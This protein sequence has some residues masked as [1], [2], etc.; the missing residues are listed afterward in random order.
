M[1]TGNTK[2]LLLDNLAIQIDVT[3][4]N[5]WNLNTGLTITSV[6]KWNNAVSDDIDLLDFG[7]TA[8]DN[9]RTESMLY[10]IILNKNETYLNLYRVGAYSEISN[11]ISYENLN[12]NSVTGDSV[13]NYFN[14]NGGYFQG[15]FKLFNY[16]YEIL[17]A[18][19][20]DGYTIETMAEILS[21]TSGIF[22]SMGLRAED[23]YNPFFSGETALISG[24]SYIYGNDQTE[25]INTYSGI[26]T[27]EGNYLN[28]NIP[29]SVLLDKFQKP[30]NSKVSVDNISAQLNNI[31]NNII[32]FEITTDKRLKY[33]F[34]DNVGNL[35]QEESPKQI[36][37]IGWTLIDIVFKPYD[38]INDYNYSDYKCY[39]R[40]KGD[41]IFYI[42][43]RIFW[44]VNN[45]DEYYFTEIQN[46]K[47]KQIG[48]P[49]NISWGGGS[50][51]LKNSYH[52]NIL[53]GVTGMTS[54]VKDESKNGL[55]IET[56]FNSSFIGNMQKL[57]IYTKALTPNE[58]LNNVDYEISKNPYY[59]I[60]LTIGGRIITQ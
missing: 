28:A 10:N 56:Y 41:L 7:L 53:S 47:E 20:N 13:G 8:F 52:F 42:N 39:P 46:D 37:R 54:I 57:R 35:I 19:S 5:S 27:S 1:A 3:N 26:T 14:L 24:S 21:G 40:R 43:G 4:I 2:N 48:V 36:T 30:E 45:F 59:N 32:S 38:S 25:Y 12:I 49:F 17:P 9:G 44:R 15:F 50:F 18:R 6:N 16:N 58:V 55:L 11:T 51:G 33:K 22:Y 29:T 23:K 31:K 60:N 34:I